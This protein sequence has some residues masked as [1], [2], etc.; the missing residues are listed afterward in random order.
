MRPDTEQMWFSLGWGS[1]RA[2]L[3]TL[4]TRASTQAGVVSQVILWVLESDKFLQA[5]GCHD[6]GIQGI[7]GENDEEIENPRTR[8]MKI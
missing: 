4:R 1:D 3:L 2:Q 5:E 7:G 6:T 8:E